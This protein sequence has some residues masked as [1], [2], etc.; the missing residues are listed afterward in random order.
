MK[1]FILLFVIMVVCSCKIQTFNPDKQDIIIVDLQNDDASLSDYSLYYIPDKKKYIP[2][3]TG[4]KQIFKDKNVLVFS[5]VWI[6]DGMSSANMNRNYMFTKDK[7]T[8]SISCDR[9]GQQRNF[10]YKNFHFKKGNYILYFANT[11]NLIKGNKI[12]NLKNSTFSNNLKKI[13]FIEVDLS[14]TI[15]VKLKPINH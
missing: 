4:N 7:D 2:I 11:E 15:N 1:K 13:K 14:D 9:C 6:S 12:E 10:H 3:K 5:Q 8:M